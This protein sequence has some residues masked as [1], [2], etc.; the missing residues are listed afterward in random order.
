MVSNLVIINCVGIYFKIKPLLH[1][2]ESLLKSLIWNFTISGDEILKA[3]WIVRQCK[4]DWTQDL[5]GESVEINKFDNMF[6]F[7]MSNMRSG[8]AIGSFFEKENVECAFEDLNLKMKATHPHHQREVEKK[9]KISPFETEKEAD[10]ENIKVQN[11]CG[12]KKHRCIGK[13]E[14][15]IF[16][17]FETDARMGNVVETDVKNKKAA[18]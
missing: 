7:I 11:A 15:P 12:R 5:F 3:L 2:T 16:G 14:R 8:L 10:F 6:A 4:D 1:Y 17:V 13:K 18:K 9:D